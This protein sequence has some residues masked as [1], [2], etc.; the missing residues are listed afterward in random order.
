MFTLPEGF[1]ARLSAEDVQS[2]ERLAK[3][4]GAMSQRDANLPVQRPSLPLT[5]SAGLQP[6]DVMSEAGRKILAHFFARMLAEEDN[7]R[8]KGGTDPIHDMRVATRRLRSAL[9]TFE[10]YYH[11]KAIKPFMK[12]LRKVARSLGAVRDLDVFR[13][14]ADTYAESLPEDSRSGLQALLNDWQG[15]LDDA[16]AALIDVLDGQNYSQFV[17]EFAHFVTTPDKDAIKIPHKE[18]AM[19]HRV[20]HIAPRLIYQRYEVVRAYETVLDDASLDTLHMLRID[21]KRL[22]YM[23]E[24][25]EEVLGKEVKAVIEA[26]KTIQDHLGDLQDARVAGVLMSEYVREAGEQERTSAVLQYMAVREEEK[27]RLLAQ[28]PQVWQAFTHPDLRRAL[29]LSVSVL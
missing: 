8:Q 19:P 12:M 20:R 9:D 1:E 17:A 13:I 27:Q 5:E 28:V 11:Y 18:R 14:K 4:E 22:R 24:S 25:F 15:Q 16:R 21:A 23:L 7:V 29:A 2:L 6:D 3:Q 26:S 10:A